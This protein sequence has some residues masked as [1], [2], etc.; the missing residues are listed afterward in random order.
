[1][2][3]AF[4][5]VHLFSSRETLVRTS[6]FLLSLPLTLFPGTQDPHAGNFLV[7]PDGRL[8]ILDHGLVTEIEADRRLALI[9]YVAH[10]TAQD[11]EVSLFVPSHLFSFLLVPIPP[12]PLPISLPPFSQLP[13]GFSCES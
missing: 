6:L 13:I 4:I 7:T 9:E 2:E 5:Y 12:A 8:A 10:L 11:W 1:M 3:G